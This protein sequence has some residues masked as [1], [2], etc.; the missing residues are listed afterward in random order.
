MTVSTGT[1]V[2]A[3]TIAAPSSAKN[4]TGTRDPA[5]PICPA[6]ERDY[7]SDSQGSGLRQAVRTPVSAS[8]DPRWFMD[9]T[10]SDLDHGRI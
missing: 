1:I 2:D 6:T 10:C 9:M 5:M 4:A 7:T 3:T 8:P